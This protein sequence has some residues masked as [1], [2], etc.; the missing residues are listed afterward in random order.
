MELTQLQI[1]NYIKVYVGCGEHE[2]YQSKRS[3]NT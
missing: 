2:A 1:T 3:L